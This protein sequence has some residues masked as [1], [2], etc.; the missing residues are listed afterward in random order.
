MPINF[1]SSPDFASP[2]D[3]IDSSTVEDSNFCLGLPAPMLAEQAESEQLQNSAAIDKSIPEKSITGKRV[4]HLINGEHYSGAERVQDLLAGNLGGFGYD[5]SFAC[6]KPELFPKMRRAT[7][8]PLHEISMSSKVDFRVVTRVA[9]LIRQNDFQV[10]HTHTPRTSLIGALAARSAGVPMIFHV[11]SPTSRDSTRRVV[12]WMNQQVERWSAGQAAALIT[13]SDSLR[14]HMIDEGLDAGKIFVVPNGVPTRLSIPTRT[15]PDEIWKL[16]TVAL[17][18]ERKG[19]EVLLESIARL[20]TAGR[21]VRLHAVGGFETEAYE[22]FLK[23]RTIELGIEDAVIW[24]GFRTDISEQLDLMDLFVLPSLF[25]EGMP[26]VVLE[27][28]AS[29][30]PVVATAVE[31]VPEVI[32]DEVDGLLATPGDSVDL[33]AKIERVLQHRSAWNSFRQQA[34][35]RHAQ[36]FSHTSMA[37]GVSQVYRYVLNQ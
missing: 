35:T 22:S 13:V 34:V 32:R 15:A 14:S 16:G 17:F 18:R 23:T 6:L 2:S 28:M 31:G 20:R 27:A 12:N 5:V 24:T 7:R 19:T 37:R 8:A 21:D 36:H 10:V 3:H 29:G 11:H 4:L 1:Q 25:G 33:A 9:K 26:M 30:V